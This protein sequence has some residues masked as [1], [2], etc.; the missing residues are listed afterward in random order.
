[1]YEL[2]SLQQPFK[3][4]NPLLIANKIVKGVYTPIPEGEYSEDLVEVVKS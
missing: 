1:M 3:G 4:D 2:L